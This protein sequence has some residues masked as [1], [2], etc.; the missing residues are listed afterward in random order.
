[1]E[2]PQFARKEE[3]LMLR[4]HAKRGVSKHGRQQDWVPPFETRPFGPLLR[5]RRF[6][7]P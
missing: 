6:L 7:D 3:N 5:V 1:M 2:A 4:S